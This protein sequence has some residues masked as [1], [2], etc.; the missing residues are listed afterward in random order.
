MS[1]AYPPGMSTPDATA[2]RTSRRLVRGLARA[3]GLAALGCAPA[4][5]AGAGSSPRGVVAPA[6]ASAA[7]SRAA[8]RAEPR[9]SAAPV[10]VLPPR[11]RGTAGWRFVQPLPQGNDLHDVAGSG[12]R[13]VWA[14][15]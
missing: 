11:P 6:P 13:D 15:G 5:C 4:G 8:T 12:P 1:L 9:A 7:A 3:A 10:R 14:V 2:L